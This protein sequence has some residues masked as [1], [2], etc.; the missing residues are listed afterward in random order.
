[1]K[2]LRFITLRENRALN[3]LSEYCGKSSKDLTDKIINV[4]L[5]DE[6][7]I[8]TPEECGE[9]LSDVLKEC[10]YSIETFAVYCFKVGFPTLIEILN[11]IQIWGVYNE[12]PECGSEW[13]ENEHEKECSNPV[14]GCS[15]RTINEPDY[16]SMFKG[17]DYDLTERLN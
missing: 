1:M 12:C 13:N 7:L 2:T 8:D 11:G 4:L 14:C 15:V 10:G 16:D 9:M 5:S 6:I 17:H 3:R